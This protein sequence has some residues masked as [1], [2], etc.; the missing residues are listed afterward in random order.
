MKGSVHTAAVLRRFLADPERDW[1]GYEL[2]EATRRPSGTVYPILARLT[3]EGWLSRTV[4]GGGRR[5]TY[6]LTEE[7]KAKGTLYV[8]AQDRGVP[9]TGGG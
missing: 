4:P 6:R 9:F 7:G 2:M 3:R 1:Y 5:V 8:G